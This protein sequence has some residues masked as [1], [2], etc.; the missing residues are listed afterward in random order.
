MSPSLHETRMPENT[1]CHMKY[2]AYGHVQVR[3][4][5][6]I[7]HH[8]LT[9]EKWAEENVRSFC[10]SDALYSKIHAASLRLKNATDVKRVKIEH[11]LMSPSDFAKSMHTYTYMV[12]KFNHNMCPK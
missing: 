5:S 1:F 10:G 2:N 8:L 11:N 4:Q 6:F 7:L 12:S 3:I 9:G